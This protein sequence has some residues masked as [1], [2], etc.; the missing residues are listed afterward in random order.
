MD[1][2]FWKRFVLNN[3]KIEALKTIASGE[4]FLDKNSVERKLIS[5]LCYDF[6][7]ELPINML[8]TKERKKSTKRLFC[9]LW[10]EMPNLQPFALLSIPHKGREASL[11]VACYDLVSSAIANIKRLAEKRQIKEKRGK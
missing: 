3:K 1:D 11:K 4:K 7:K 9:L 2:W 5:S 6:G 10:N 8:D